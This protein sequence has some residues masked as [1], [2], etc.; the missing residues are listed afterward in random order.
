MYDIDTYQ[1]KSN[2][3]QLAE[4]KREYL[5]REQTILSSYLHK[6]MQQLSVGVP[7]MH[8][9]EYQTLTTRHSS[10]QHLLPQSVHVDQ[11]TPTMAQ[12][13]ANLS[14]DA[15]RLNGPTLQKPTVNTTARL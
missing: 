14:G 13:S 4:K 5:L 12:I 1:T 9:P 2:R 15:V 6:N 8:R 11:V 7:Q 10:L 3:K